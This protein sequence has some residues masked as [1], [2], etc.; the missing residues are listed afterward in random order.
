V[1]I[2]SDNVAKTF[3]VQHHYSASYPAA[4]F[5]FGLYKGP[6]LQGVAVFSHPVNDRTITSVF[7]G[8]SLD[9]VE[10]G[11]F[12]LLDEVPGNGESWMIS[13]CLDLLRAE[14]LRGVVTFSDPMPRT[15]IEGRVIF[16]R[17]VGRI[18]QATN[19]TYLGRG[20]KRT[21][22]ILPDGTVFSERTLQKIRSGEKGWNYAA[23]ILER[24]GAETCPFMNRTEWLNTWLPQLTRK[25]RHNGN[26][27]YCWILTRRAERP[28]GRAYPKQVDENPAVQLAE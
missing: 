1:P 11:R 14:G 15:S 27:K 19:A 12:V 4:R 22:R 6:D 17:H 16:G 10:L 18:Y 25:L 21:L 7:P 28:V 13:R 9:G 3:V 26:H 24:F 2:A 5:R 20:T 8:N 23:G